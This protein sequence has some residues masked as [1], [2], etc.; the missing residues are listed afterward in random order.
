[1]PM[2]T[3]INVVDLFSGPGG[4]GEGFSAFRPKKNKYEPAFKVRIS[5][6]M[7]P[8]AHKTLSLRALFRLLEGSR[9]RA[10]YDS[11]LKREISREDLLNHVPD[12][13]DLVC[14]ET[15]GGPM[16]LGKDNRRI[17]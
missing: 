15:L 4:L 6:E 11:Y 3:I 16:E 7:D 9:E 1:R 8:S 17:H 2:S 14:Q 5:V 12:K 10:L 13:W